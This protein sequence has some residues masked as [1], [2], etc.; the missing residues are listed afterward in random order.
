[1]S[2]HGARGGQWSFSSAGVWEPDDDDVEYVRESTVGGQALWL[3]AQQDR[4]AGLRSLG[5]RPRRA[6]T[7]KPTATAFAKATVSSV[8]RAGRTPRLSY[9]RDDTCGT[10]G[11]D[12]DTGFDVTHQAED[13]Y[14]SHTTPN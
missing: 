4:R 11:A 3:R 1:M 12:S 7:A 14:D 13:T 5:I 9:A 6:P 10:V 2:L 8:H